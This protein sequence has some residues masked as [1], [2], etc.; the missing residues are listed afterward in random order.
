MVRDRQAA[1]VAV[2]AL[3]DTR[4][5]P[6][7]GGIRRWPYEGL[8]A[9]IADVVELAQAMTWKCAL[10][11]LPA[12]GGKAVILDHA[13]LDRAAAYRLVG[14]TVERMAGRFFTGPDVGTTAEDLDVVAAQ[15][16]FVAGTSGEGPGDL[17]VATATGVF[18]AL[19]ALVDRLGA[20]LAGIRVA[21]QGLGAVGMKLCELLH[22][23]GAELIVAD[24]LNQRVE[25]AVAAF[26]AGV[27]AP[28]E[29]AM[30]ACDVFAPCALGGVLT[31]SVAER[32][33]ARGV[34]GAANNIFASA[35][36]AQILHRR[37]IPVVP[38]FVANA[39]GLIAGATWSI[40]GRRADLARIH[41]I[42]QTAAGLLRRSRDEDR[43]PHE[44]ALQVAGERIAQ[45]SSNGMGE[46]DG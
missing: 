16:Q 43:P 41:Q 32:L 4:L 24:A 38:D 11:G 25:Q 14:R 20:E 40:T 42:Q 33:P 35:K 36:A 34:C 13:G 6:A 28:G 22:D 12:G 31:E 46:S 10:A 5:G 1:A 2:V 8:G 26:G 23:A 17:A 15:T 21:V 44:V 37:S 45:G 18:A 19:M 27:T 7:H 29:I 39:G 30:T 3:H 9:A